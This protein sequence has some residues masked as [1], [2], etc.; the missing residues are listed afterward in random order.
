[1][2]ASV[3][4]PLRGPVSQL[5]WVGGEKQLAGRGQDAKDW[6]RWVLGSILGGIVTALILY[7]L[8]LRFPRQVPAP[9]T[10]APPPPQV[11][12]LELLQQ[13]KEEVETDFSMVD[14]KKEFQKRYSEKAQLL[15]CSG[16]KIVAERVGFEL[17]ARNATEQPD[18][19]SMLNATKEAVIAACAA[20]P[21]PLA[22]V[23]GAKTVAFEEVH[24]SDHQHLTG[25]ELRRA[26]VAQRSLHRL[27]RVLLSDAKLD[28]LHLMMQ[29][30]VPHIRF[31]GQ[32]LSDNWE[33]WLC[34]RRTRLCKRSEVIDDDEDEEGE[35]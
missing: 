17:D 26:E 5:A 3:A 24:A 23:E 31:H 15:L 20:L 7:E 14:V 9:S 33:R 34:A 27:C 4:D 16:C 21:S 35:L 8:H 22:V 1:M 29:H 32:V 10:A 11:D 6:R 25:I 30:K 13:A 19:G 2:D 28:M 18:P 12:F